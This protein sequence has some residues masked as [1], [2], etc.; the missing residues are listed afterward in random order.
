MDLSTTYMGMK[1]ANP[2]ENLLAGQVQ[3]SHS[4]WANVKTACQRMRSSIIYDPINYVMP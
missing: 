1:L 3:F 2:L 4:G